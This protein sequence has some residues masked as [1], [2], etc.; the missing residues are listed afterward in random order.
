MSEPQGIA[1]TVEP[2]IVLRLHRY[3]DLAGVPPE[4]GRKSVRK[5]VLLLHGASGSHLTFT[6][7]GGGLAKWLF[8]H[9]RDPWLLDW[10]GS[11]RVVEAKANESS[12]SDHAK[13][14]N[15]NAASEHD[16][17]C[18]IRKIRDCTGSKVDVIGF[19]MGSAITA[20]AVAL[21]HVNKAP[22]G[23]VGSTATDVER[24]VL[25]TLGLF[26]ETPVDGKLKSA[27]RV[28]ERIACERPETGRCLFVDP[29]VAGSQEQLRTPWPTTLD[30]MYEKWPPP[31]KA[32]EEVVAPPLDPVV[33]MCNRLSFMYGNIYHH[34]NLVDKIHGTVSD[35]ALLPDMFGGIP[36]QMFIHGARNIRQGHATSFD[37]PDRSE[38]YVRYCAH[39][40]FRKLDRVT[41]ITGA[42]NRLWHRDS[43]DLMYEWLT[44]GSAEH[45][46]KFKKH[47]FRAY[48]HQDLLWGRRS[49]TDVFPAILAGLSEAPR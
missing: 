36:L 35:D 38:D 11:G 9:D 24:I 14:Y 5:P 19:C 29:R 27:D 44:R 1:L 4:P 16:V 48:G 39:E 41:L 15:F 20:E 23:A 22:Q 25:M 3:A 28:L 47:V 43:I 6:K 46:H 33:H 42:L 31:L 26:Y 34:D 30:Q 13:A 21:G 8:E 12:L 37:H 32:H 2:G 45:L 40:R 10:R 7:P 18:A 49:A 17:P